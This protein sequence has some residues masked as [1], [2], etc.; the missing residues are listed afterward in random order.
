MKILVTIFG[1]LL[2]TCGAAQSYKSFN[3]KYEGGQAIY[4][5]YENSSLTRIFDGS[6]K[7]Q[8]SREN[9]NSVGAS[10]PTGITILGEFK[11]DHKIG[12][13]LSTEVLASN[14][15]NYGYTKIIMTYN[16]RYN[17]GERQGVWK[18]TTNL[19]SPKKKDNEIRFLYFNHNILVGKIDLPNIKGALDSLG[20]FI[21]TWN[22]KHNNSEYIVQFNKNIM[23]S[24]IKR[25]IDDGQVLIRYDNVKRVSDFFTD[26]I[27]IA[28]TKKFDRISLSEAGD[29]NGNDS[30]I[31]IIYEMRNFYREFTN[32]V[33]GYDRIIKKIKHGS[34]DP[35]IIVPDLIIKH[36]EY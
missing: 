36:H 12:L 17:F 22:L 9:I 5:Y 31:D 6:F 3:G 30:D 34:E 16:G 25:K 8:D 23:Q 20:N 21:D 29:L 14:V 2:T 24:F 11:E 13:W 19:I 26:T 1:L 32:T 35:T 27:N 4:R 28:I 15:P 33:Q 7:F 18:F 10:I